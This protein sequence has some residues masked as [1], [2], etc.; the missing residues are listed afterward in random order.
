MRIYESDAPAVRAGEV[1]IGGRRACARLIPYSG[2]PEAPSARFDPV[3][4]LF[5]LPTQ[6]PRIGVGPHQADSWRSAVARVPAGPLLIGP[7]SAA[8]EIHGAYRAAAEG[9]RASGRA[10]Y[11]LEP[12]LSGLPDRTD[13]AFVVLYCWSGAGDPVAPIAGAARRGFPTGLLLPVIPGWTAEEEFLRE[14]LPR[15]TAAGCRSVSAI[16]PRHDGDARRRIVEARGEAEGFFERVHH[17]DWASAL[18]EAL[19]TVRAAVRAHGFSS[20][21]ARPRAPAEPAGNAR[22]AARL[23]ER[24]A[25][26]TDDHRFALLHAAARWIDE[27]GRD[28][29]AVLAE[30]N[31]RKVFPF[32]PEVVAEAEKALLETPS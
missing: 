12:D 21:P 3:D 29:R 5:H 32:S 16:A 7:G 2:G 15:L 24:A 25:D 22:A 4:R 8:E 26:A 14:L 31:F 11:L 6:D 30:G 13:E 28:L 18:P 19:A 9:T 20:L 1:E 10:A 27:S 17:L 23:E